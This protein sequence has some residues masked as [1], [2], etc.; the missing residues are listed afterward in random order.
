[1]TALLLDTHA[2]IWLVE[3]IELSDEVVGEIVLA[4]LGSGVYVSPISAWEIGLLA[5]PKNGTAAVQFKPD[6]V[7]WFAALMARPIIKAAPF[8]GDVAIASSFL[9]EPFHRDPAD[10]LLVATARQ[11]DVPIVTRDRLIL[12][13]GAAGHVKTIAC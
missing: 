11:M 13:Y 1:M 2:A 5:K 12:A 7:S 10:R 9:P 8:D 3:G 4:G 6:P